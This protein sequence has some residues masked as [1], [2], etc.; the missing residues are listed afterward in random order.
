MKQEG[1][2]YH[3][4]YYRVSR[5]LRYIRY[6]VLLVLVLFTI[7]TFMAFRQDMTL[8]HFRYL[9]NN[10]D[11][12]PNAGDTSGD[13]L[14]FDADAD[15]SFGF[16]SGGF[17]TLTDTRVFVTDR[18]SS[19][20]L[21]AYHGYR[22]PMGVY[23]DTYMLIYDRSG[24]SATVYNAFSALK[25]FSFD[26]TV[27]AAACA[28]NGNF[29]I[30]VAD[31]DGYYTRVHIYDKS[32][33]EIRTL[34]KYKYV[35]ALAFAKEDEAI[36]V[37]S[38]FTEK[39]KS[40]YE[41]QH[42][43]VDSTTPTFTKTF[44]APIYAL[45]ACEKGIRAMTADALF[46][47]SHEG[48]V[49]SRDTLSLSVYKSTLLESGAITVSS[50]SDGRRETLYY[51]GDTGVLEK[52]LDARFV[53][54]REDESYLY[55]LLENSLLLLDKKESVWHTVN[56]PVLLDGALTLAFDGDSVYLVRTHRADRLLGDMLVDKRLK[57]TDS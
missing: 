25:S 33:D 48:E 39:G 57:N 41:I 32:F 10:F 8:N 31:S 26:G 29:A 2:V 53:T 22:Q 34:S 52:A 7:I 36:V 11:F 6:G 4:G 40:G 44:D 35:T 51:A 45:T 27:V 54:A 50:S 9:L 24:G 49:L 20:T 16:V 55:I 38:R 17:V 23:S 14:Y 42:L 21:S 5:V 43:F 37:G 47:L 15:A 28:D 13:V 19:T 30:A 18:S 56:D 12:S 46:M 3:S 1:I